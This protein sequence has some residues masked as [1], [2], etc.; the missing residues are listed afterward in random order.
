[1]RNTAANNTPGFRAE[2][3]SR[4]SIPEL[5]KLIPFVTS[6]LA[7]L[8][9]ICTIYLLATRNKQAS[10]APTP[11]IAKVDLSDLENTVPG[12]YTDKINNKSE[13]TFYRLSYSVPGNPESP[14]SIT[15]LEDNSGVDITVAWGVATDFYG[16]N[17]IRSGTETFTVKTE[18][19]VADFA[20]LDAPDHKSD[21][22]LLLIA[23]GTVEH[24]SINESLQNRAFYS[25]GKIND[26]TNI[27]KFYHISTESNSTVLAQKA[28]GELID[29]APILLKTAGENSEEKPDT[30]SDQTTEN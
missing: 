25:R 24:I 7:I 2:P 29:L 16:V 1:M 30:T 20:V 10:T 4:F 21:A 27:V 15:L 26:L 13:N 12:F 18:L 28:S 6:A 17:L 23:D 11:S 14:L 22:V 19:P 8:F 5:K 9:L 3:R